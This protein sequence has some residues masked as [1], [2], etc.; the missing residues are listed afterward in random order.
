MVT[1]NFTTYR[2]NCAK[3]RGQAGQS[4]T[5]M[6]VRPESTLFCEIGNS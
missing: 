4:T 6:Q 1:C 2:P 5:N 3:F